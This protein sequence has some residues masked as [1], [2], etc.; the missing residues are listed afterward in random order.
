MAAKFVAESSKMSKNTVVSRV[1]APNVTRT[2]HFK[3][4]AMLERI[5]N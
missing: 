3:W 1:S 2:E 5:I 4:F